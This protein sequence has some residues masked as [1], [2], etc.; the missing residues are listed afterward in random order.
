MSSEGE[1]RGFVFWFLELVALGC[2]LVSIEGRFANGHYLS[3]IRWLLAGLLMGLVGFQWRVI[4]SFAV[5]VGRL[6]IVSLP[7]SQVRDP[8][9]EG[10]RAA[11][12]H[13]I[14]QH[15]AEV[16]A[17]QVGPSL[18][19]TDKALRACVGKL[20][21]DSTLVPVLVHACEFFLTE[22]SEAVGRL[23][24]ACGRSLQDAPEDSKL[25][26]EALAAVLVE[27]S[28]LVFRLRHLLD[29][30]HF[31]PDVLLKATPIEVTEAEAV[32]ERLKAELRDMGYISGLDG[33]KRLSPWLNPLTIPPNAPRLVP[34]RYGYR[35]QSSPSEE[36]LFIENLGSPARGIE[37]RPIRLGLQI[38]RFSHAELSQ[39]KQQNGERFCEMHV[40]KSPGDIQTD[41]FPC[42]REW[43]A[44]H[45]DH[46]LETVGTIYYGDFDG[47]RYITYYRLG[48]DVLN[49]DGGMVVEFLEQRKV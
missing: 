40:E 3:G 11:E 9:D 24:V 28:Y 38:V 42:F 1:S 5:S 12:R 21:T 4:L 47:N 2:V 49:A 6:R 44:E 31:V 26:I 36:G 35:V 7:K 39:L 48:V 43:Q 8:I 45:G 30:L 18:E 22:A 23:N 20:P 15:I 17:R 41:L 32:T 13:R 34:V 14:R 33:M 16:A 37:V 19:A 29:D 25:S 46:G 27:T 10:K